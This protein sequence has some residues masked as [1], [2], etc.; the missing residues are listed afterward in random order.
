MTLQ[1]GR[2]LLFSTM[3]AV[4]LA[5]LAG[6]WMVYVG[7]QGGPFGEIY[8]ET[9]DIDF[10]ETP[11][12]FA[13]WVVPVAGVVLIVELVSY[14]IVRLAMRGATMALTLVNASLLALIAGGIILSVAFEHNPQGE[15][16]DPTTGAIEFGTTIPLFL[17]AAVPVALVA[18]AVQ[19][20]VHLI[21]RR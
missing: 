7:I 8:G 1:H 20:L 9:G 19:L 21:I 17:L 2:L 18:L 15:F 14:L 5:S 3:N 12:L 10:G 4:L 16:F 11:L 6:L 13:V